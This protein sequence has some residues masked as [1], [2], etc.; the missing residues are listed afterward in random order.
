MSK[1]VLVA[2]ASTLIAAKLCQ[3]IEPSFKRMIENLTP[4]EQESVSKKDLKKM[5]S[6]MLIKLGFDF[7]HPNGAD[8]ID[9]FIHLIGYGDKIQVKEQAL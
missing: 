2:T 4:E 8:F 3:P 1:F 9:R 5:E 7:N 6:K